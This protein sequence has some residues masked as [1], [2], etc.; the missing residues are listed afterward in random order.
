MQV[1]QLLAWAGGGRLGAREALLSWK[2]LEKAN[3]TSC[4]PMAKSGERHQAI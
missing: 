4:R 3:S 1:E 2:G